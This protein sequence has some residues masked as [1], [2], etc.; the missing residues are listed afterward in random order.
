[1]QEPEKCHLYEKM[2][3]RRTGKTKQINE[4]MTL[5][6]LRKNKVGRKVARMRK[7]KMLLT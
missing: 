2:G 6:F 5:V 1:M 7:E 3:Y 4:R